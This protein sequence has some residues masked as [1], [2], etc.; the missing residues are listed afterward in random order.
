MQ[1]KKEDLE[2]HPGPLAIIPA[3][4]WSELIP[5]AVWSTTILAVKWVFLIVDQ[6][7]LRITLRSPSQEEA[8]GSMINTARG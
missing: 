1:K 6:Q 5:I 8:I 7:K 2:N 3:A 4:D